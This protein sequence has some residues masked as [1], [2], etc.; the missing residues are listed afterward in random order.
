LVNQSCGRFKSDELIVYSPTEDDQKS[1]KERFITGAK[2]KEI[3]KNTSRQITEIMY[4]F[5]WACGC[6]LIIFIITFRL[7]QSKANKSLKQDK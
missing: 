4:L 2:A 5:G 3:I 6:F 1:Y 7:E